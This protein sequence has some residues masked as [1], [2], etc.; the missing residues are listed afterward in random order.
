MYFI[1][2]CRASKRALEEFDDIGENPD[3]ENNILN[4]P[5]TALDR[6]TL[7]NSPWMKFLVIRKESV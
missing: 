1:F 4:K 2:F 6:E 3:E 7:D 5:I